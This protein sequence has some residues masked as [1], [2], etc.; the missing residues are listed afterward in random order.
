MGR[1]LLFKK[2]VYCTMSFT[3]A[4][5]TYTTLFSPAADRKSGTVRITSTSD[6]VGEG[7]ALSDVVG[8]VNAWAPD[9][10]QFNSANLSS[11]DIADYTVQRYV[12]IALP[13]D[14]DGN[15]MEGNYIFQLLERVSGAVDPGDY[16]S[17]KL[18]FELCIVCPTPSLTPTVDCL[19]G[20]ISVRD[21][22]DYSG[23]TTTSRTLT[24]RPPGLE[25]Q[26]HAP[27]VSSTT[28]VDTTGEDIFVGTYSVRLQWTGS[29]GTLSCSIDYT[30]EFDSNCD[31][32]LCSLQ[33]CIE[34]LYNSMQSVRQGK[35]SEFELM[36]LES[37]WQQTINLMVMVEQASQCGQ[38]D[39]VSDY[40]A[41]IKQITNCSDGCG[42]ADGDVPKRIVPICSS[43]S[44]S[45]IS[46]QGDNVYTEVSILGDVYTVTLTQI[47]KN[48]LNGSLNTVV[49]SSD[50]TVTVSPSTDTSTFPDTVTYDLSTDEIQWMQAILTITF[51]GGGV[52][53]PSL[54]V[55]E[56]KG[57]VFQA[58]TN[59]DIVASTPNTLRVRGF[60]TGSNQTIVRAS[61]LNKQLSAGQVTINLLT[62]LNPLLAAV[63]DVQFVL[64]KKAPAPVNAYDYW[65]RWEGLFDEIKIALTFT[66]VP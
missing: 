49:T 21:T 13:I 50:G 36:R 14:V 15:V 4:S 33:C 59:I 8:A 66:E 27:I 31:F 43:G 26:T 53:T 37:Q 12:D 32:D 10:S 16:N 22:T 48:I 41:Q 29:N 30:Y 40:V 19:C 11:P 38:T 17:E 23:W 44:S 55:P 39:Q 3:N 7:I 52:I 64:T 56:I 2:F 54:S 20:S 35:G 60:Y 28:V 42:C 45:S 6:I 47:Q 58:P 25:N 1:P 18:T 51:V 63:D 24:L 57:N 62:D 65:S 9:G 34:A 46:V 61:F 5:V